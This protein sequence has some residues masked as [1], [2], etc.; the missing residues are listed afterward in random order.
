L[1]FNIFNGF[2][3]KREQ[4]NARIA[5][6]NRQLIIE[7][8]KLSLQSNFANMWMAYQN[9]IEL[10]KLEYESL[11]NARI[12]YEIA[13]DRYK[14]GDLSGL[15]LREAQNS[16]LE[17]GQRLVNAQYRTKLCEISLMQISGKI[18]EYL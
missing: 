2:N 14:L 3:R 9:N 1:G 15:E 18:E 7:K 10:T 17:A 8:Q 13:I 4:K 5:I 12:N 11:E 6:E 16:L